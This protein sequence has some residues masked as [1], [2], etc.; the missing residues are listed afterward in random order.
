LNIS[1]IE[2]K[3]VLSKWVKKHDL[4][5]DFNDSKTAFTMMDFPEPIHSD[6]AKSHK[7]GQWDLARNSITGTS[8]AASHMGFQI[9]DLRYRVYPAST[10]IITSQTGKNHKSLYC[11]NL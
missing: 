5:R 4:E 3:T 7:S 9:F 2:V 10:F 6:C 11:T 1:E 8:Y